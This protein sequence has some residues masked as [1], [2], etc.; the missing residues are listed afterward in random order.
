MLTRNGFEER[1]YDVGRF[2][3]E[4]RQLLAQSLYAGSTD[5]GALRYL[6]ERDF[7][8][9]CL[10]GLLEVDERHALAGAIVP[11]LGVG[12]EHVQGLPRLYFQV[13]SQRHVARLDPLPDD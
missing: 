9:G 2:A 3:A 10:Q 8:E 5:P 4:A 1:H 7:R 12:L 6:A 11:L 13:L